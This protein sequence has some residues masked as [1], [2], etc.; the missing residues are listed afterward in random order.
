ML[1]NNFA[2]NISHKLSSNQWPVIL[3]SGLYA[4]YRACFDAVRFM[5]VGKIFSRGGAKSGFFQGRGKMT[6]YFTQSKLRKRHFS[7]FPLEKVNFQIPGWQAPLPTHMV[8][9]FIFLLLWALHLHFTLEMSARTLQ[10]LFEG[11][12]MPQYFCTLLGLDQGWTKCLTLNVVV[13]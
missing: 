2:L 10:C 13:L 12:C 6:I 9:L 1:Q 7:E 5:G 8:R 3:G 4:T 11:V